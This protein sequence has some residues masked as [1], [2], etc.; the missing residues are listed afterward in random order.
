MNQ[1]LQKKVILLLLLGSFMHYSCQYDTQSL[2]S[3][4]KYMAPQYEGIHLMPVAD[5]ISFMLADRTYNSIK[6]FN[7]F[8]QHGVEYISFYDERSR[9][10]N[11]YRFSTRQLEKKIHLTKFIKKKNL[12]K[13]TVYCQNYDSI[14]INNLSS[15]YL[16]DSSGVIKKTIEFL[17]KPD[18]AWA[19]F[20][21]DNPLVLKNGHLIA[22]VRPYVDDKALN[23]LR[24]WKVMYDF[25]L[26]K[27]TASL[28]YH[29][30]LMYQNDFYGHNFLNYNFCY[31]NRGNFVFSFPADSAVYETDLIDSQVVY[32]A[33]SQFQKSTITPVSIDDLKGDDIGFKEYKLRDSYGSILFDPYKKRYLRLAKQKI[34]E[35]DFNEK[36]LVGNETVI[37]FN[38]DL[39]I[40]GE[41]EMTKDILFNSIL[42]TPD[43]KMYARIKP[44]DEYALYF[45]R[46]DYKESQQ[47]PDQLSKSEIQAKR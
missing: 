20:E 47:L 7:L 3:R 10:I 17:K 4:Y 12:Y 1:D 38:E 37:I 21:N 36:K 2:K 44:K 43:G 18:N 31:N 29:L 8:S 34:S 42:F 45:V 27:G 30:P 33:K 40:I 14:F 39:K 28:L 19:I 41:S 24:K 9:S 6:S 16:V 32:F 25:D 23:E 5:T 35:R 11:I 13:T 26:N 15:L 46:L 22:A